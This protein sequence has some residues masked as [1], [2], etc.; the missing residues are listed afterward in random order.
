MIDYCEARCRELILSKDARGVP[1]DPSEISRCVDGLE[2]ARTQLSRGLK[3]A[4]VL[5]KMLL[6]IGG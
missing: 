2:E 6:K 3:P 1:I 4:F 5:N